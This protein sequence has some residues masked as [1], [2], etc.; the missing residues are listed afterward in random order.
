MTPGG[1]RGAAASLLMACGACSSGVERSPMDG[2]WSLGDPAKDACAQVW[3]FD[4][5]LFDLSVYCALDSGGVG[6]DIT[7]GSFYITGGDK[8]VLMK[9]RAT[10]ADTGKEPLV[11]S[12]IVERNQLTLVSPT[13]VFTFARGGL[14]L[15]PGAVATFGCFNMEKFTPG[16]LIDL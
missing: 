10:C 8:I 9:T 2:Q 14:K 6:L 12:F 5:D 16:M 7:R 15:Q 13:N 4:H 1:F 11:L 3:T